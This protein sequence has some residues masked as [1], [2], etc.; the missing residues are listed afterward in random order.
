MKKDMEQYTANCIPFYFHAYAAC[1]AGCLR[2]SIRRSIIRCCQTRR[3]SSGVLE[4]VVQ[5]YG[6]HSYLLWSRQWN[7]PSEACPVIECSCKA[8]WCNF[9]SH[10]LSTVQYWLG[11][12]EFE[13]CLGMSLKV[14]H[15]NELESCERLRHNM[16]LTVNQNSKIALQFYNRYKLKCL[17][18][19]FKNSQD[20]CN[21]KSF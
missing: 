11:I 16:I 20:Y 21:Q 13:L 15:G 17:Y 19:Y 9:S 4:R 6:T 3:R 7:S 14:L 12:L 1:A 5:N 18:I 10:K 8:G 2:I